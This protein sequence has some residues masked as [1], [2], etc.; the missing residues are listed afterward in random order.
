MKSSKKNKYYH[1]TSGTYVDQITKDGFDIKL[2]KVGATKKADLIDPYAHLYNYFTKRKDKAKYF[3]SET[4]INIP[5]VIKVIIPKDVK[6]ERDPECNIKMAAIRCK[7]SIPPSCILPSANSEL[8]INKI[9]QLSKILK[10]DLDIDTIEELKYITQ[11]IP[12]SP[13]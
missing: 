9:N 12:P 13:Q 5:A 4:D 7:D 1:G 2:K 11:N 10:V 3:A 6:I 8:T